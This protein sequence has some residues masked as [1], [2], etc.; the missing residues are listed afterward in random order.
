M[1]TVNLEKAKQIA[2]NYRRQ[3][4]ELEFK[5]HDELI[6][7]QIPGADIQAAEAARQAIRTKYAGV[8]TQIDAAQHV[9]ELT[10][11]VQPFFGQP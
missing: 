4:R 2:H 8:Q 6:A 9:D 3:V 5:P 7:K 11:I 10:E 1:I